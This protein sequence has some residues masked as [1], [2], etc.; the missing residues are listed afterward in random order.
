MGGK[1]EAPGKYSMQVPL[2]VFGISDLILPAGWFVL[3]LSISWILFLILLLTFY[4]KKTPF[5]I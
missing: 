3:I 2:G 1:L 4:M 5:L